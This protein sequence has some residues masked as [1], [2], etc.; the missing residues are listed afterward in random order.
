MPRAGSPRPESRP[1]AYDE[2]IHQEQPMRVPRIAALAFSLFAYAAGALGAAIGEEEGKAV[3]K[4]LVDDLSRGSFA[5]ADAVLDA[6]VRTALGEQGTGGM[7]RVVTAKVGPLKQ[8]G[9]P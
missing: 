8:C 4:K 3:A 6:K 2:A 5:S 9:E 7:W 1:L